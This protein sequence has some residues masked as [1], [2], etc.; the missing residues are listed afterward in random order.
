[1]KKQQDRRC[2]LGLNCFPA[3][4]CPLAVERLKALE[5]AGGNASHIQEGSLEGCEWAINDRDSNYC[6]FRYIHDNAG[7]DHS[8]IEIAEKLLITQAA[9]YSG[10]NRAVSKIKDS[11]LVKDLKR[12]KKK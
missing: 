5:R 9:V 6:F 4:V 8:T 11:D 2:P 7:K 1:M 10:L 12:K 3:Q